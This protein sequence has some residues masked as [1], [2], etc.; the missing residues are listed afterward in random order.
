MGMFWLLF[1]AIDLVAGLIAFV[2]EKREDKKLLIWLVPMR[3][4]YRQTM[5]YVVIKAIV[6]ALRGPQVGWASIA[7]S[8]QARVGS[9]A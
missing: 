2:L 6:Q 9:A 7:R 3:F 1:A 8:G 5:Y 4:V